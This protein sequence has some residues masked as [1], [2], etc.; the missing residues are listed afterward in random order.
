MVELRTLWTLW[1]LRVGDGDSAAFQGT[2]K[3]GVRF[4]ETGRS[5]YWL[6]RDVL[7]EGHRNVLACRIVD[8]LGH[9][10]ARLA[11]SFPC[12]RRSRVCS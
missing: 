3:G 9:L 8:A 5:L 6:R 10:I 12:I 2:E 7:K 11:L 4:I 1:T